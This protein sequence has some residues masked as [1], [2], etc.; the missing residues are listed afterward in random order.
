MSTA[1]NKA[2]EIAADCFAVRLRKLSREISSIYDN[3]FKDFGITI[4]QFNLLISIEAWGETS[5][6]KLVKTL[7]L[8]KSTVSRNLA[9]MQ[10]NGW[11]KSVP[12]ADR[13]GQMISLTDQG[14]TF[15]LEL[16][17]HWEEAQLLAKKKLGPLTS[18]I[19]KITLV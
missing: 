19:G 10:D 8:E 11:I 3:C 6:S 13:R 16:S 4:A 5:P 9:K 7:S 18:S 14:S 2:L 15:L 17:P 1:H 12:T